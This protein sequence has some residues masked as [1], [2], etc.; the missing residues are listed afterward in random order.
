MRAQYPD[1]PW[2]EMQSIRNVLVQAYFRLDQKVI[3]QTC[4]D[5]IPIL[6]GKLSS[7]ADQV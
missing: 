2:V 7:L 4:H 1:I 3:W 6:K 5:D